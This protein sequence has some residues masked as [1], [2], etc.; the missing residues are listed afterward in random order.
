MDHNP[1]KITN[2]NSNQKISVE[3]IESAPSFD[4]GPQPNDSFEK[5]QAFQKNKPG[6]KRNNKFTLKS[7]NKNLSKQLN[8]SFLFA[9]FG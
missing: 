3:D 5:I 7:E 4:T 6:P 9:E 8:N 2:Q 1:D